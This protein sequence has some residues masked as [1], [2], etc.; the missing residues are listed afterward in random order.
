ME[1][2]AGFL[3][4]SSVS[5][6]LGFVV[7][8]T[9]PLLF[10]SWLWNHETSKNPAWNCVTE[11]RLG[12]TG[13]ILLVMM[14]PSIWHPWWG[15]GWGTHITE[16]GVLWSCHEMHFSTEHSVDIRA[17]Y[18]FYESFCYSVLYFLFYLSIHSILFFLVPTLS[19]SGEKVAWPLKLFG[20]ER[21]G[22]TST[23]KENHQVL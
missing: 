20:V 2:F 6:P 16:Q 1:I 18:E 15:H 8:L 11:I 13:T 4:G 7:P 10:W 3:C 5:V 9:N 19:Q 23:L 12:F 22:N 21:D 14:A 17:I